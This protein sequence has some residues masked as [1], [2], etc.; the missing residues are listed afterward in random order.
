M[1][2]SA[3][4]RET[5]PSPSHPTWN[6]EDLLHRECR[7]V[8]VTVKG[9]FDDAG[10]AGYVARRVEDRHLSLPQGAASRLRSASKVLDARVINKEEC[11]SSII[12][13]LTA[14]FNLTQGR[15]PTDE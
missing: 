9:S 1:R 5:T 6:Q 13:N 15:Y 12:V 7:G 8:R 14:V 3:C 10:F 11:T 2:G 4:E